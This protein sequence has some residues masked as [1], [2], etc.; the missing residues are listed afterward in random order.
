MRTILTISAI[1]LAIAACG[2]G[3]GAASSNSSG[4]DASNPNTDTGFVRITSKFLAQR[5]ALSAQSSDPTWWRCLEGGYFEGYSDLEKKT[6]CYVSVKDGRFNGMTSD[7]NEVISNNN[8][9]SSYYT[10]TYDPSQGIHVFNAWISEDYNGKPNAWS[11]HIINMTD[12]VNGYYDAWSN[13]TQIT[14]SGRNGYANFCYLPALV[15]GT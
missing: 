6:P 12:K 7:F 10:H 3:G 11:F 1:S 14:Y 15:V 5:C 13:K 8:V 9:Q 2:G 4:T